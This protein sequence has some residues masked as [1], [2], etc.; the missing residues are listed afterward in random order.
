MKLGSI[1]NSNL[2]QI[3]FKAKSKKGYSNPDYTPPTTG[4]VPVG[5]DNLSRSKIKGTKVSDL[6]NP[7]PRKFSLGFLRALRKPPS[8][9]TKTAKLFK[10][11]MGFFFI[12]A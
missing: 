5:I 2:Y 4:Y 9:S 7:K 11:P 8:S 6:T 12:L 1:S 3:N 10:R